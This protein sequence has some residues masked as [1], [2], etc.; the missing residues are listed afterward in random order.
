MKRISVIRMMGPLRILKGTLGRRRVVPPFRMQW[1]HLPPEAGDIRPAVVLSNR[2]FSGEELTDAVAS[3]RGDVPMSPVLQVMDMGVAMIPPVADRPVQ[4]TVNGSVVW[5]VKTE[6]V[7]VVSWPMC[8]RPIRMYVANTA[9]THSIRM[10]LLYPVGSGDLKGG[11]VDSQRLDHWRTVI[12][13]PGIVDSRVLSVCYDCLC[14]MAL[15]RAVMSLVHHWAE[16]S[17]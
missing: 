3:M 15:F 5:D 14:L 6:E 16:W 7:S 11:S 9:L 17:V 10:C 12:W 2:L 8:V 1:V 13:D 4:R